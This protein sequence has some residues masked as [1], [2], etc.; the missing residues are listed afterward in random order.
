M[1]ASWDGKQDMVEL[2]VENGAC[3]NQADK[4]NGFT[5]LI[6]AVWQNH[7]DIVRYLL[8]HNADRTICS[9]KAKTALDIAYEKNSGNRYKE[10]IEL[11]DEER[12]G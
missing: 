8:E 12:K 7:P 5:A 9:F 11:L 6:K 4:G 2:L 1:I 3:I 10:I